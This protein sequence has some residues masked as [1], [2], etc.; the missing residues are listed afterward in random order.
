M[1]NCAVVV[2][3]FDAE[4]AAGASTVDGGDPRV[5]A[6]GS[7]VIVIVG[8]DARHEPLEVGVPPELVG[9]D[10]AVAPH[11]PTEVPGFQRP[12]IDIAAVVHA[13]PDQCRQHGE[14]LQH[15]SALIEA[16]RGQHR[17]DLFGGPLVE[18]PICVAA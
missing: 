4:H 16:Q 13:G 17:P 6:P 18:I 5:V 1:R 12:Q 3:R 11:D 9:V 2:S 14:R 10:R 15:G 7:V 8:D